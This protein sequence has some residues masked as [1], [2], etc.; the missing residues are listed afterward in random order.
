M[1]WYAIDRKEHWHQSQEKKILQ[2]WNVNEKFN[3][4]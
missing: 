1:L 3:E 2:N 4:I